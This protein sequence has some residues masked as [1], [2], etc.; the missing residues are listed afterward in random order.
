MDSDYE[1][2]KQLGLTQIDRWSQGLQHHPESVRLMKF[3]AEHDCKDYGMH[4]DWEIGGDGD[5]GE[6]L[7]FQMDAYFEQR[8]ATQ[9][10]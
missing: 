2:A 1:K 9:S 6:T 7:M 8:D 4:F 3:L 10:K 5:N